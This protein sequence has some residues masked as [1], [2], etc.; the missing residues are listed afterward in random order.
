MAGGERYLPV[1][2]RSLTALIHRVIPTPIAKR[3]HPFKQTGRMSKASSAATGTAQNLA[4]SA[5]TIRRRIGNRLDEG[6]SWSVCGEVYRYERRF[7]KAWEAYAR[8]EEI[9]DLAKNWKWLGTH[10]PTAGD[11]PVP[12]RPGQVV[13]LPGRI[14][15]RKPGGSSRWPWTSA[16]TRLCGL[17]VRPQPSW[18]HLLAR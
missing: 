11:L 9:F 2:P 15:S 3:W 7:H 17:P 10:L 8:A 14:P 6:N 12:G 16:M 5:I 1:G 13:L 18:P 4:E